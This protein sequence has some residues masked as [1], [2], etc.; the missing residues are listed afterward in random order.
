M[1]PRYDIKPVVTSSS[2]EASGAYVIKIVGTNRW[3]ALF[4]IPVVGKLPVELRCFLRLGDKT[5][6][7]TWIY[8]YF[9]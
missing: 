7:E 4:D 9:A 6:S 8:Q 2:G 3:R 1:E 5:L